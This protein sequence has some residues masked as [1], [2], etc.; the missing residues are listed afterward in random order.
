LHTAALAGRIEVLDVI[1]RWRHG[2]VDSP[3]ANGDTPL[4]CAT[5]SGS[6]ETVKLL[7]L[8]CADAQARNS[9]GLLPSEYA[10]DGR[11]A[12]L[13]RD[14]TVATDRC[15]CDC[16]PYDPGPRFLTFD[17]KGGCSATLQ[18]QLDEYAG[19]TEP[20]LCTPQSVER[21]GSGVISAWM[22]QLPE[23]QCGKASVS[24]AAA[25]W[26]CGPCSAQALLLLM[27]LVL[28][29]PGQ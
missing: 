23:L 25:L 26:R 24:A 13:I 6:A 17:W 15:E 4:H 18:C 20:L 7:L 2:A 27:A 29:K 12:A 11:V 21:D 1:L 5:L 10:H 28:W 14:A 22:P 16:G 9:K 19:A 3:A 8:W